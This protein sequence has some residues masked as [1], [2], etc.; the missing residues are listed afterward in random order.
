L[1]EAARET[2]AMHEL[3]LQPLQKQQRTE[4]ATEA[5]ETQNDFIEAHKTP[6]EIPARNQNIFSNRTRV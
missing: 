6:G 4:E 2:A 1:A 5:K 3:E